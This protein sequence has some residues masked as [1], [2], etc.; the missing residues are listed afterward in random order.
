MEIVTS[1]AVAM[2]RGESSLEGSGIAVKTEPMSPDRVAE[3]SHS[4]KS[5]PKDHASSEDDEE[6]GSDDS[7][8]SS[9]SEDSGSESDSDSDKPD[10]GI[11]AYERLRIERIRRNEERLK[12]L[13]LVDPSKRIQQPKKQRASF[14]ATRKK[15][16]KE[17][18]PK[19]SQ[20]KR[21]AKVKLDHSELFSDGQIDLRRSWPLRKTYKD[22]LYPQK[23]PKMP[24]KVEYSKRYSCGECRACKRDTDCNTCYFCAI[25]ERQSSSSTVRRR[26]LFRMCL[27]RLVDVEVDVEPENEKKVNEKVEEK[28]PSDENNAEDATDVDKSIDKD[29]DNDNDGVRNDVGVKDCEEEKATVTEGKVVETENL[30]DESPNE[31]STPKDNTSDEPPASDPDCTEEKGEDE[32]EKEI[33]N[34]KVP[35]ENSEYF[36]SYRMEEDESGLPKWLDEFFTFMAT[37]PHGPM[38]RTSGQRNAENTMSQVCKLVSGE[39]VTYHLWPEGTYF[40]RGIKIHLGHTMNFF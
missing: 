35:I 8:T 37:I 6:S 39:G 2:E 29:K 17:I 34:E 21:T 23:H 22:R 14:G 36:A 9:S 25:N 26:C 27:H 4:R 16:I 28:P 20:P 12:Q 13:G 10:D 33:V 1:G 38:N 24:K 3:E 40:K 7:A 32:K 11:S 31:T 30:T 18:V 15:R 19:R 5:P